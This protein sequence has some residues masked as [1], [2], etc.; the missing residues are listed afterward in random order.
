M[1]TAT[2]AIIAGAQLL[3]LTVVQ[4]VLKGRKDRRDAELK[5]T[6]KQED[7]ARQDAVA[8]RVDAAAKQAADAAKLL[9]EAQTATIARTDEVARLAA[10]SDQQ[11][12]NQLQAIDEQG[13]QIHILVNSDMTAA[14]TNERDQV[15]LT[16]LA[17][18]RVQALSLKLGVAIADDELKAIEA[19]E[20]RIVE[21]DAI[22]ADRHAAQVAIEAE[23]AAEKE[24]PS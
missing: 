8:A 6:E 17:L 23:A 13:K 15:R 11:I 9:V 19:A 21:L 14:R 2:I 1:E 16:L 7:Y 20:Q 12:R 4:E 24:R 18:K 3:L 22:L 10:E 5:R